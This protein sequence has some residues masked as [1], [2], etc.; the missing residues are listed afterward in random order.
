MKRLT[1]ALTAVVLTAAQA[2]LAQPPAGSPPRGNPADR[3][4]Q[5]LSLTDTQKDKVRQI[6]DDQRKKREAQRDADKA[7][8]Q[9]PTPDQRRTRGQADEQ[10][11]LSA[12]GGVLTPAQ[13]T[14]FKEIQQERHQHAATPN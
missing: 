5:E 14:K 13:L 12:L 3:L 2:A 6:F 11:L 7:S 1:I 4:A 8:G 10:E 9:T